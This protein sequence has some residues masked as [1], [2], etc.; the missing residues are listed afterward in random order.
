MAS[1]AAVKVWS[2]L[3]TL[4]LLT[5]LQVSS[6]VVDETCNTMANKCLVCFSIGL[7][8][9]DSSCKVQWNYKVGEHPCRWNFPTTPCKQG[10]IGE[11]GILE[12]CL[13]YYT[14]MDSHIQ[15]SYVNPDWYIVINSTHEAS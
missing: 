3:A 6:S 1:A 7:D 11:S 4:A 9:A 8:T 12:R 5:V 2:V 14:D 10:T 15:S 13:R